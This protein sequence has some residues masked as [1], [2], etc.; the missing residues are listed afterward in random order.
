MTLEYAPVDAENPEPPRPSSDADTQEN[1]SIE[2]STT[3]CFKHRV[4]R[5]L[6]YMILAEAGRRS[7]RFLWNNCRLV[8]RAWD[9]EIQRTTSRP[10]PLWLPVELQINILEYCD[11]AEQSR[12]LRYTCKSWES[13]IYK[14]LLHNYRPLSCPAGSVPGANGGK[15]HFLVH[16]GLYR[17]YDA[18]LGNIMFRNRIR[19]SDVFPHMDSYSQWETRN[20]IQKYLDDP[21]I[22]P[23]SVFLSYDAEPPVHLQ[24]TVKLAGGRGAT[25]PSSLDALFPTGLSLWR[26]TV[27]MYLADLAY[28]AVALCTHYQTQGWE[29]VG[30]TRVFNVRGPSN[31]R[32]L[33]MEW[34]E[35][36]YRLIF[37]MDILTA[38][39]A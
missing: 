32:L 34:A 22:L 7:L 23:G 28:Y 5:E 14:K 26:T 24:G 21:I 11:Y 27:R 13:E 8:C 19:D 31:F 3:A 36:E 18:L 39:L 16:K 1:T 30:S 2:Q 9:H 6:Q 29:N 20:E 17:L 33:P 25:R 15:Y 4:P 37:D 35:D 10:E 12:V 38:A